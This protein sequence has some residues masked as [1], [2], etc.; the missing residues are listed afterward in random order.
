VPTNFLL[1]YGERLTRRI[2]PPP[3][4]PSKAHPYS[5]GEAQWRLAPRIK[6]TS[7]ELDDLPSNACPAD[8]AVAVLTLHPAYLA[9]SY[10]PEDLL[11]AANLTAIG[12]RARSVSPEKWTKQE[13]PD[14][15]PTAE[16]FVAGPRATFREWSRAVT[17]WT[18][19]SPGAED[20]RKI[21]EVRA[22]S[23]SERLHQA[24][25]R[26]RTILWEIVLH[27]NALSESD[28]VLD[29]FRKYL[30]DLSISVDLDER[31]YA[32]GLCFL[33]L[34]ASKSEIIE[35]AKFS[36]LRVAR[37]MPRLRP[38]TRAVPAKQPIPCALPTGGPIDSTPRVAVFD[39]GLPSTPNLSNWVTAYETD[40][41][42]SPVPEFQE[43]GL[44][45]TSALL[46]G[47]IQ[48]GVSLGLPYSP[49]HHYRVLD[50][51]SGNDPQGE[52]FDV[53]RRIKN[54]LDNHRYEYVNISIGPDLPV[55]DDDVHVWTAVLDQAFSK[56]TILPAIA[57]GNGGDNDWTSGNARIQ[58]PAD[59]VNGMTVGS[60]DTLSRR[61]QRSSHSSIGPG[62]SPGIVKP[63]A[64]AFGGSDASPFFVLDATG[65]RAVPRLGTSFAS[66][67]ALR[68][69][70][71]VRAHLG[72]VL[73][74]IAIRALLV[75]RCED[76]GLPRSEV[77]WGRIPLSIDDLVTSDESTAHI[78]YQGELAPAQWLR[79]PIPVPDIQ[80]LGMVQISA[81]FCFTS[82]TDPQDPIHYTRAGLEVRFRPNEGSRKKTEQRNPNSKPFFQAKKLYPTE[83]ELRADAHKW[84]TILH[85]TV[86]MRGSSLNNP[87]FDI[88]YHARAAG[89]RARTPSNIPY[90]LIVTVSAP[91]VPDLY[92]RIVRRYRTILEA[93]RPIVEIPI[94]ARGR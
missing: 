41:I 49:V 8:E 52:L 76:G 3:T 61:W 9:K 6:T 36:F 65:S 16:I 30:R 11:T 1:G 37:E 14:K 21:E 22:F 39:G 74:P 53:L 62:R 46:F 91:K 24:R 12:S 63:D 81:T 71:G 51:D 29:G 10:F 25:S 5:F 87:F 86:R 34:R 94:R 68:S 58:S 35:V 45:V 57:A 17:T 67:T 44:G 90:A 55:D 56:G 60:C 4:N 32:E 92:D 70:L 72:P 26:G 50:T 83:N 89:R 64:L 77:G 48:S 43:H 40:G 38:V 18:E 78:V 31:L 20:L 75:H 79:A 85:E 13:H 28:Y 82:E 27:A 84:E 80:M 88:H 59:C 66:P 2:E 47:P 69:G 73:T 42:G 19:T 15:A 54:V 7:R 93:L 23:S 33:P